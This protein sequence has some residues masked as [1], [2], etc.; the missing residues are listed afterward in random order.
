VIRGYRDSKGGNFP[1]L[2]GSLKYY[3]TAFV[4]MHG[5]DEALDEDRDMLAANAGTMLALAEGTLDEIAVP[6]KA[7]GFWR[8][9]TDGKSRHTLVYYSGKAKELPSLAKEADKI[10]AKDKSAKLS[11]YVYAL[12]GSV[13]GFENEFDDMSNIELKPIPEPILDIYRTVNGN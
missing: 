1:G 8:H 12:G 4:G 9:Y 3:K 10:R 5:C 7:Q 2:G 6:K 13:A 11:V